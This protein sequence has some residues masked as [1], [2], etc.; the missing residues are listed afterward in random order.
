MKNKVLITGGFG[1]IGGHVVEEFLKDGHEVHVLDINSA[2]DFN[3]EVTH[4]K[5]SILN[6]HELR[7]DFDV[8]VHLAAQSRVLESIKNPFHTLDVNVNGTLQMLEFALRNRSRFVFAGSA[9]IHQDTLSSPY[10]F[11]KKMGED[12]CKFYSLH[13]ELHCDILRFYNV[14]GPGENESEEFGSLIGIWRRRIRQNLPLIINGDGMQRRDFIYVSDVASAIKMITSANV[15]HFEWEI[16]S[17]RS[18]SVNEVFEAFNRRFN[19]ALQK[20]NQGQL[21]NVRVS[22]LENFNTSNFLGWQP[23]LNVLDYV[24]TCSIDT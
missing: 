7:N 13:H 14:F 8:I 16:G 11:S 19:G 12:L 3:P 17:G 4:H 2:C 18:Y 10:A 23:T 22:T 20:I 15:N 5:I 21:D 24:K 1:F 6:V 9:S